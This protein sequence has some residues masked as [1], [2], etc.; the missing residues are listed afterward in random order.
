MKITEKLK[1]KIDVATDIA[2]YR[3]YGKIGASLRDPEVKKAVVENVRK[4]LEMNIEFA[5][6]LLERFNEEWQTLCQ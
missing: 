3:L 5:K 2:S 4:D 1:Q 6:F